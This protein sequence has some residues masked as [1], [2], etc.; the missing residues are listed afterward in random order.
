MFYPFSLFVGIRYTRAKRRS[1]FVSVISLVTILCFALA[2]TALITV[3]SVM[4]GFEE[5]IRGRAFSMAQQVKISSYEAVVPDWRGLA[6]E[7]RQL[8]EVVAS[9]PYINGQ[10]MLTGNG[11]AH[12]VAV[13]GILPEQQKQVS[14]VTENMLRGQFTDLLAGEYGIILGKNLAANLGVNCGDS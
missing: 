13:F 3:L 4:N 12:A 6:E 7:V 5:V 11:Q 2:V 14:E 8:P 10:G 1:Q 9:A